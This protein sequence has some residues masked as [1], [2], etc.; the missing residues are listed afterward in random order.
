[1]VS[2]DGIPVVGTNRIK[3][4]RDTCGRQTD[5]VTRGVTKGMW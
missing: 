3:C 2:Y 4:T 5:K 1:M